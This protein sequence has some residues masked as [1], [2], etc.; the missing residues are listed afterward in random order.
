MLSYNYINPRLRHTPARVQTFDL[1]GVFINAL[2][3]D[4]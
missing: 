1:S 4:E 2:R 3:E